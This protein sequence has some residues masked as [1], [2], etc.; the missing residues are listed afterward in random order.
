MPQGNQIFPRFSKRE[1]VVTPPPVVY[2]NVSYHA[3]APDA[4]GVLARHYFTESGSVSALYVEIG[5][6]AGKGNLLVV[7]RN[8]T[9]TQTIKVPSPKAGTHALEDVVVKAGDKF[10]LQFQPEA[11]GDTISDVWTAFKF[12]TGDQS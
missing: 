9:E 4:E 12:K 2:Q 11:E 10:Y 8:A 6:W 3:L 7:R 1:R 5:K